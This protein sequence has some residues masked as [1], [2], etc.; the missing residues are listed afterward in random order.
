MPQ[1]KKY[2]LCVVFVEVVSRER[3]YRS[4]STFSPPQSSSKSS[5]IAS[6][7]SCR[8][9]LNNGRADVLAIKFHDIF[10]A[11][12]PLST[13]SMTTMLSPS[14]SPFFFFLTRR[15]ND[16]SANLN[17]LHF[18]SV[19]WTN[20]TKV[21]IIFSGFDW[22][23]ACPTLTSCPPPSSAGCWI[24]RVTVGRIWHRPV[25]LVLMSVGRDGGVL[26]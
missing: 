8:G 2:Y 6:K 7:C 1:G 11:L 12:S 19:E 9:F 24:V 22:P 14:R 3:T 26:W 25:W 23:P 15:E 16:L 13:I 5:C 18:Y 21:D 17:S 20:S 4:I 10:M